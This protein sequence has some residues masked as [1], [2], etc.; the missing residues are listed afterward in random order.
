[1]TAEKGQSVIKICQRE[2]RSKEIKW[3]K[4]TQINH[5]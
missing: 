4:G 1:M 3:Y 5:T 2:Q